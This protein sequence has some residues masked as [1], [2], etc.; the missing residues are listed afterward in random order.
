[1][2]TPF[3][4]SLGQSSRSVCPALRWVDLFC[5][6]WLVTAVPGFG[7]GE[8]DLVEDEAPPFQSRAFAL[9]PD[10]DT[11]EQVDF[12]AGIFEFLYWLS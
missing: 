11:G 5:L 7:Q 10:S 4:F 6:V 8:D 9:E 1:M 12:F 2:L 3:F